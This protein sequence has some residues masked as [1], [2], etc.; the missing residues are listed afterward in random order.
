MP[1]KK[2]IIKLVRWRERMSM[3]EESPWVKVSEELP[4]KNK[5]LVFVTTSGDPF[6]GWLSSE[7]SHYFATE[8]KG[9]PHAK[10]KSRKR[11]LAYFGTKEVVGW[12]YIPTTI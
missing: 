12:L 4:E 9:N 5:L 8:I 3:S 1:M 11:K 10:R 6:I 7:Y 2:P